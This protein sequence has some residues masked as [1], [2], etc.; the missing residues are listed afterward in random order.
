[1]RVMCAFVLGFQSEADEISDYI[2]DVINDSF[3]LLYS[4]NYCAAISRLVLRGVV[5]TKGEEDDFLLKYKSYYSE[6]SSS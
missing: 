2:S 1:M 3:E 5:R 4:E 6:K